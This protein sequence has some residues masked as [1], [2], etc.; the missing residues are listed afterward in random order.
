MAAGGGAWNGP[1]IALEFLTMLRLRRVHTWD[2]AR[3]GSA[4]AWFP[5]V[6]LV[7][8]GTLLGLDHA[9]SELLPGAP[10][11]AV[12]LAAL[13]LATGGLHLDGVADTA[14]GLAAQRGRETRL[15]I[16]R[17]GTTGPAGVMA[18][19]LLLIAQWSALAALEGA[20]RP[21]ALLLAPA[22]ARWAVVPAA[23]AYRPARPSGLGHA[24]AT[25]LWPF[26]AP[27]ATATAAATAIVLFGAA[28]LALLALAAG[29][30][31]IT[32][33]ASARMFGGITGDTYGAAVELAQTVV[34]LAIVA[35][36]AR[37]WLVPTELP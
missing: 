36:A 24:V 13:A 9:L 5:A 32:A 7:L 31:L 27:F 30:A 28:G 35:G 4:L 8:G 12:L 22:L 18:L 6:G 16:M 14:D 26:A 15:A 2:D 33:A 25:A 10:V 3:F 29:A 17:E 37:G 34:W 1:L 21:A 20:A 11:A 19:V 23:V